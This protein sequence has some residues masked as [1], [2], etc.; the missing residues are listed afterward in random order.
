MR[1]C[2]RVGFGAEAITCA[3]VTVIISRGQCPGPLT[4]SCMGTIAYR[5]QNLKKSVTKAKNTAQTQK[6]PLWIMNPQQG[7]DVLILYIRP[8]SGKNKPAILE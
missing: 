8:V 5:T 3:P 2:D 1:F 6:S 4:L 7:L